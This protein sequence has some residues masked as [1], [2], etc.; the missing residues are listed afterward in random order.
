MESTQTRRFC[1]SSGKKRRGLFVSF[2]CSAFFFGGGRKV[3]NN[4]IVSTSLSF[5]SSFFISHFSVREGVAVEYASERR[6]HKIKSF[7]HIGTRCGHLGSRVDFCK[8]NRSRVQ[9]WPHWNFA[10][11]R[12]RR[13]SQQPSN[14]TIQTQWSE[15]KNEMSSD[16]NCPIPLSFWFGEG[17]NNWP[18]MEWNDEIFGC[19][20]MG[21]MDQGKILLT[22]RQLERKIQETL[23]MTSFPVIFLFSTAESSNNSN[24]ETWV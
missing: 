18:G 1:Y 9:V 21:R 19:L 6:R 20:F 11:R 5:F 7:W 22:R 17:W 8:S 14:Q 12:G 16:D 3:V 13:N 23:E 2:A 4:L 15:F 10:N 24:R